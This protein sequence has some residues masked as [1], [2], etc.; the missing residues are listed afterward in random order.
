MLKEDSKEMYLLL[1]NL[2]NMFE[3]FSFKRCYKY[4]ASTIIF[5]YIYIF[6]YKHVYLVMYTYLI[7]YSIYL[8]YN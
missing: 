7:Q 8:P 6:V 3:T 4:T 1:W 2:Y 5:I